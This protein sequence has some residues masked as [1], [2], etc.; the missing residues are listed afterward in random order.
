MANALTQPASEETNNTHSV[1]HLSVRIHLLVLPVEQKTHLHTGWQ[2]AKQPRKTAGETPQQ[3][4]RI[5]MRTS[6]FT[7]NQLV[8]Q[9]GEYANSYQECKHRSPQ[10]VVTHTILC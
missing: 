2:N 5:N 3:S 4:I 9:T 10:C 6:S 1:M 8:F 7:I